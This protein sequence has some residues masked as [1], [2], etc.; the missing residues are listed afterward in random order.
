[1]V[2]MPLDK[3]G[4]KS[5]IGFNINAERAAGKPQNQALA[6]ALSVARKAHGGKAPVQHKISQPFVPSI[7]AGHK[8]TGQPKQHKIKTK[9]V[10]SKGFKNL[11]QLSLGS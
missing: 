5:S 1:M 9:Q 2:K 4:S 7:P 6:I 3:S 10:T 8:V 11:A